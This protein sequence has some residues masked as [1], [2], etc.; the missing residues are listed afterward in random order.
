[1]LQQISVIKEEEEEEEEEEDGA[2]D[3]TEEGTEGLMNTQFKNNTAWF[4]K[5][6]C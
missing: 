1:M 4:G 6:L 3:D 5:W 2:E